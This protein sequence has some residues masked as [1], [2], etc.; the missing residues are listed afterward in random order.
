MTLFIEIN[1]TQYT[2]INAHCYKVVMFK[3]KLYYFCNTYLNNDGP[4]L[5]R[6]NLGN[7]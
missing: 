3:Q 6:K 7:N 5:G 4:T 2:R 1:T